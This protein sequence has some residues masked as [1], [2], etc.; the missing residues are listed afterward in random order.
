MSGMW[1]RRHRPV[2]NSHD[3]RAIRQDSAAHPRLP[4]P[5]LSP[6]VLRLAPPRSRPPVRLVAGPDDHRGDLED[7]ARRLRERL[8]PRRCS[9]A[10]SAPEALPRVTPLAVLGR[11]VPAGAAWRRPPPA[12]AARPGPQGRPELLPRAGHE[13]GDSWMISRA[14]RVPASGQRDTG[15]KPK[16]G[17][18]GRCGHDRCVPVVPLVRVWDTTGRLASRSDE[19]R[20]GSQS[21][22]DVSA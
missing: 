1:R 9:R 21:C 19:Y 10:R 13:A 20:P 12:G 16:L 8:L 7:R 14:R 6:T 11:D 4:L 2:Q 18:G 17:V 5:R 15:K 3:H 22:W